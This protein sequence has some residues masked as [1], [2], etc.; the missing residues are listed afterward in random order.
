MAW[1]SRASS[2]R[3]VA[4]C[5]TTSLQGP[6]GAVG[7]GVCVLVWVGDWMGVVNVV[8]CCRSL[9]RGL[10]DGWVGVPGGSLKSAWPPGTQAHQG[11]RWRGSGACT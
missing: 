6:M 3:Y 5:A 7:V 2:A 9:E 4:Y 11:A 8:G 10:V 1:S